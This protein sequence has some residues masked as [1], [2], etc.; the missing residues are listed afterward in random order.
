[1]TA[2]AMVNQ[3]NTAAPSAPSEGPK[4]HAEYAAAIPASSSTTGYLALMRALQLEHLPRSH[5]QLTSGT[6]SSAPILCPH[7]GQRERG[8]TRLYGSAFGRSWPASDAH[9]ARHSRSSI[10]GR[11]WMTTLR[12]EPTQ[13][14]NSRTTQGSTLG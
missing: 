1:M 11:R 9:S 4:R 12:N 5:A 2:R 13:R 14:P 10:F 7:D 3:R 6:F 8:T